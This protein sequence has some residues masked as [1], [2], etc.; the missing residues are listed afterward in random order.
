MSEQV[1]NSQQS[2]DAYKKF[3]D[4]QF[5]KHKYLRTTAKTG[6][7]RTLTQNRSMHLYC[8][9]VSVALND[10][11]FDFR[12]SLRHDIDVPWSESLAKDYI[13]RPVQAAVTG[14]ESTTKPETHQYSEIYE[15][16]NRHL[17][18]KFGV[19]VPWPSKESMTNGK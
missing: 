17:S 18:N 1:I 2:L 14:F 4:D 7:Q 12:Q 8:D 9:H 10:A 15:I 6:K 16:L 11:G 13:W 19:F 5:K 3:L